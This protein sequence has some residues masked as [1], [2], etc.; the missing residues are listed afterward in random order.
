MADSVKGK[1]LKPQ[2]FKLA[3]KLFSIFRETENMKDQTGKKG[4][5]RFVVATPVLQTIS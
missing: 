4:V 5:G 1:V 2:D 3:S